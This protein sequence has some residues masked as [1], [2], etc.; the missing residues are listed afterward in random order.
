MPDDSPEKM[1]RRIVRLKAS[2]KR[3]HYYQDFEHDFDLDAFIVRVE[4]DIQHLRQHIEHI[5]NLPTQNK[6][7][8]VLNT[9]LSMLKSREEVLNL[10]E[11]DNRE[12]TFRSSASRHR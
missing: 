6:N 4:E 8:T 1:L 2:A 9:Y 11:E 5:Q 10:L 12:K 3:L 7:S